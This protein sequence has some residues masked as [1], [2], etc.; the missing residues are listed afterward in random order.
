FQW[1]NPFAWIYRRE[2]ENNLEFLTDDQLMREKVEKT[3]YQLSLLKVSAPHFPLS[4]T[5][6]YNQSILKK[7]IA[8]MNTKKSNLHTTWKYFFLLPVLALFASLLNEPVARAQSGKSVKKEIKSPG[9][10]NEGY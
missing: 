4:L 10:G 8:M 9:F 1:F 3:S 2:I 6:N 7:R 5:T